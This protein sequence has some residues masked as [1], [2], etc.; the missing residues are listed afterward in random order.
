MSRGGARPGAGRKD[1][2]VLTKTIAFRVDAA[3]AE[4]YEA[5]KEAGVDVRAVFV[6]TIARLAKNL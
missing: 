6:K 1:A 4:N 5:L 3:T 2:P